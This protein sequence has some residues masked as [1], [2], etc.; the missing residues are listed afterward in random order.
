[1][2]EQIHKII[3]IG[4]GPAGLTAAY[5]LLKGTDIRPADFSRSPEQWKITP[6][7]PKESM[8]SPSL[9]RW[10]SR[11]NITVLPFKAEP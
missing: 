7:F 6:A 2:S 9:I 5:E 8:V 11:Q 3:V 4:G 10:N 1:M